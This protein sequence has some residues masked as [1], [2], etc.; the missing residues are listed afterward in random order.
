MLKYGDEFRQFVVDNDYDIVRMM[1]MP[2]PSMYR[3]EDQYG[4]LKMGQEPGEWAF[5][6]RTEDQNK[7][8]AGF[9]PWE[10]L[11]LRWNQSGG[12]AYG[13]SLLA[14]GRT[15]WRKLQAMEEAL[16]INW[17][18]RAFARLLIT[19]DTTGKAP[20]EA[21]KAIDDF[22]A[23]LRR[24]EIGADL[25]GAQPLSVV[26]DLILGRSYHEIGG[27]GQPSLTDAKVL[28]MS[29]AGYTNLSAIEYYRGKVLMDL[30]TP[31]AYLGLEED[32]NAKATLTQEDRRY[33][34]FL[35][36]IQNVLTMG[37]RQ[38]IDYQLALKRIDPRKVPYVVNWPIPAWTDVMDD[39]QSLLNY[40][41]AD[42][43]LLA[44]GIVDN[45]WVATQHLHMSDAQY[46]KIQETAEPKPELLQP[47][48]PRP[49]EAVPTK[50]DAGS[51]GRG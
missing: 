2:P 19:V 10:I 38:T 26:T 44:W 23:S 1:Y 35:Q 3:N 13:R 21:K 34:K 22:K 39:S 33:S 27:R 28:D 50:P 32:I 45:R 49:P 41:T 42:K 30:R 46:E 31:K 5:E 36:R 25:F 40:V 15:S 17:I 8:V 9:R 51:P 14:T 20:K 43:E 29:T 6:Q 37:I 4:L 24:K 18:T 16:V 48:E 47:T 11:H 7:L 12:S